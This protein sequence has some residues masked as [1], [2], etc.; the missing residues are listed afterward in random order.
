MLRFL[1]RQ[2][3]NILIHVFDLSEED[4]MRQV[5]IFRN[6]FLGRPLAS[7]RHLGI[8]ASLCGLYGKAAE[9]GVS[10]GVFSEV[11]LRT[12]RFSRVY[13]IDPWAEHSLVV[14]NDCCN[15]SQED[16]E[17]VY[18]EAT[19][20][21][22]AYE[23]RNEILRMTSEEASCL[24]DDNALDFVYIDANHSY[25]ACRR[26]LEL[27]WPKVRTGGIFAGHDYVNGVF[28]TGT[29]GVKQAVDEFVSRHRQ[30]L[31]VIPDEWPTWYL[32]KR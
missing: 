14:Y 11:L 31:F 30:R 9:I 3:R 19:R 27:W 15:T 17:A 6:C 10:K 21:L 1:K 16:Q 23:E 29:Y 18:E 32:M 4:I 28:P 24:F 26:D 5:V 8:Y 20:R 7:R 12:G 22:G 25:E 2:A 13:S